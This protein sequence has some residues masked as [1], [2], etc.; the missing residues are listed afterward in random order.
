MDF[1]LGKTRNHKA[2]KRFFK[3][4]LR[5]FHISNPCVITLDKYLAYLCAESKKEKKMP[6]GITKRKVKYPNGNG[7]QN[8][9][10]I[11]KP[12]KVFVLFSE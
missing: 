2:A 3:K 6:A 8:Y 1:Y 4:A 11:R 5:S 12:F 7:E 10:C 9:R